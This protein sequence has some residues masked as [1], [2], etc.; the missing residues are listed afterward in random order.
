MEP[1]SI[2]KTCMSILPI[3]D[4]PS[5]PMMCIS[6]RLGSPFAAAYLSQERE[7]LSELHNRSARPLAE[8]P[9]ADGL[10]RLET[11]HPGLKLAYGQALA[12]LRSLQMEYLSGHHVLAA[13]LPESHWLA[14]VYN[15]L[16]LTNLHY[17]SEPGDYLVFLGR[18][19]PE[20]RPDRAIE[21]AGR[22]GC[23]W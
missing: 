10:P 7:S 9:L 4:S 1:R 23:V 8:G 11:D 12:D 21:I 15:G 20:K 16:D 22:W 2:W 17:R 5:P 13:G 6:D 18:I 14:N 3:V 19:N